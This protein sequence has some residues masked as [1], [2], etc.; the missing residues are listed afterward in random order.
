[1]KI[2]ILV[3]TLLLSAAQVFGQDIKIVSVNDLNTD[4]SGTTIEVVGDKND[5]TIYSD[6]RVINTSSSDIN[7]KYRRVREVNSGRVDQVCDNSLCY[8]AADTYNYTSPI[9]NLIAV[10]DSSIF[11]PQLVPAG[12]E[13][14]A[15]HNYYVVNDFG[16]A[17]DSIRVVFRT[18]NADCFL[19]VEKEI[20]ETP[21]SIF[22]NPAQDFITVKG[23]DL[24]NGGT[25]V[26]LDALGKEVKR[27][28]VK[29]ANSSI[30]VNDLKRGVYFVNVYG[31][32]G[33]KS[34]IQRLIIQ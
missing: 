30:S 19:S 5:A 1:M 8:D 9:L 10:D 15:I 12:M 31:A 29:A 25:V 2:T 26:F 27:A 32:N 17:F 21:F 23:G 4:I 16:V 18:T 11:K 22:P 33:T 20:K 24:K 7:V 6:F 14:C 34:N 3:T 13:S 28:S